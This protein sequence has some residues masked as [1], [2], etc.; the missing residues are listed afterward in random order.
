[1][2]D[3]HRVSAVADVMTSAVHVAAAELPLQTAARL[4]SENG[5]GAL[6]VIDGPGHVIGLLSEADL[7]MGVENGDGSRR[8]RGAWR[9][10]ALASAPEAATVRDAMSAP[11]VTI[12]PTASIGEAAQLMRRRHVRHLPVVDA[13]GR[14]R[15]IVSR[16]DLLRVFLRPDRDIAR[17]IITEVLPRASWLDGEPGDVRVEAGLVRLRGAVERHSEAFLIE[18]LATGVNGVVAVSSELRWESDDL[19]RPVATA[20]PSQPLF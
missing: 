11:V 18:R 16:G 9:H 10:P 6:P 17:Q 13:D 3:R 1:M 4:M 7:S 15:G 8:R 14:L 20:E 19:P 5:V 2:V 12:L